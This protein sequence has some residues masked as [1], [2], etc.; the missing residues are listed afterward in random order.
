M[1]GSQ[2]MKSDSNTGSKARLPSGWMVL[3]HGPTLW[4]LGFACAA[5]AINGLLF[6]WALDRSFAAMA[7]CGG[8]SGCGEV[9]G[10]RWSQVMGIPVTVFGLILYA[11]VIAA[12]VS[13]SERLLHLCIWGLAGAIGWFAF[14]Q[15]VVLQ[16]VCPWCM[17]AHA[18]GV[19]VLAFYYYRQRS[20]GLP[21]MRSMVLPGVAF[22]GVGA[23]AIAQIFGPV[24]ESYRIANAHGAAA[25]VGDIHAQGDGRQV[26]FGGGRKRYALE[27]LPLLGAAEAQHVLAFYFDY[28]CGQCRDMNGYLAELIERYPDAVAVLVLPMPLDRQCNEWLIGGGSGQ[29]GSCELSRLALAA[30]RVQPADFAAIHDALFTL[31]RGNIAAARRHILEFIPEDALLEALDDPWVAQILEA[32]IDDWLAFSGETR[33]L[34]KVFFGS[35][36]ILHGRPPRESVFFDLI[37]KELGL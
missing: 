1:G 11:V 15:L 18:L 16:R 14:L 26:S 24:P 22:I 35:G 9:L 29:E 32:N 27:Q 19:G 21:W 31:P 5:F 36:R 12:T 30:W 7:G 20:L 23:F 4:M 2:A 13:A 10:S 3:A 17:A 37:E 25:A 6:V 28:Q 34:P 33:I 8:E